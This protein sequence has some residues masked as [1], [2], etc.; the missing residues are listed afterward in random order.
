VLPGRDLL[1]HLGGDRQTAAFRFTH[2]QVYMLRHDHVHNNEKPYQRRTRSIEDVILSEAKN[3][4]VL[5]PS[6]NQWRRR[7][8]RELCSA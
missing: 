5:C 2:Q 1:Q 6:R 3:L 8:S 4:A 7:C